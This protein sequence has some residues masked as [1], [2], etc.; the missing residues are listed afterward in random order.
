MTL[1]AQVVPVALPTS[2]AP[3][4]TQCFISGWGNTLSFGVNNPAL[5]APVT[6]CPRL[7]LKPDY[8]GEITNNMIFAGSLEGGKD[9]HQG[10]SGGPVICNGELPSKTLQSSLRP[11]S[12]KGHLLSKEKKEG[13]KERKRKKE[14][15]M[16][17]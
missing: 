9:S 16:C 7:T 13:R 5:P 2:C 4:G 15:I 17:P 14:N 3:A 6:G 8:P 11:Y 10:H 12:T 1:N